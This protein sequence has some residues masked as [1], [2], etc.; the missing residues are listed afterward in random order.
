MAALGLPPRRKEESLGGDGY[1]C[2]LMV[3]VSWVY[4]YTQL[5][6]LYVLNMYSFLYVSHSSIKCF[7]KSIAPLFLISIVS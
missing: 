1:V 2:G 4:I 5:T 6:K 7:K 3:M